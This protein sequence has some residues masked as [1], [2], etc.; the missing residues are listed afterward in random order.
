LQEFADK[1]LRAFVVW[2][3]VLVTDWSSPSTAALARLSD[4]R[5]AQFWDKHRLVSHSMGEHDRHSVV[6]DY[7]AVYPAGAIWADSPPP[8]LYHG[9]PVVRVIEHA[10]AAIAQ[11]LTGKQVEL[12]EHADR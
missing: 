7:I 3:P 1:P 2:E 8:A 10:R 5:T 11:T 9:N 6:W 12:S 4:P